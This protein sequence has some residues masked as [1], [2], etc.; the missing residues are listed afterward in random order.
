VSAYKEVSSSKNIY[1][2][3]DNLVSYLTVSSTFIAINAAL[4]SYFSFMVYN[5]N[6]NPSLLFAAFLMTFTIYNLNKL[7]DIK[8]DSI[9]LP[10]RAGFIGRNK[11]LIAYAIV[12]SYVAAL[13]LS[14][15]QDRLAIFVILFPMLIGVVYSIRIS[16]FRLKD[17]VGIKNIVIALSWAVAGSFLPLAVSSRNSTQ[18][19]STFYFFFIRVFIGSIAFDIR[20]IEGDRES[21]VRT[22]PVV[23]GRERT[24]NL[25]LV[26]NSTLIPWLLISYLSGFFHRYLFVFIFSILYGYCYIQH[27]CKEGLK[28]GRS[29]D[30]LVDGEWIPVVIFARLC[31]YVI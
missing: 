9:N 1:A 4:L 14:F 17:I 13:F 29:L 27:F 31:P 2:V 7:T 25:L 11:K 16:R 22:I 21:G 24:K 23:F 18:I 20:D 30:L 3:F 26:L 5:I 6:P 8:E 28:I 15:I 12:I 10:E 19:M